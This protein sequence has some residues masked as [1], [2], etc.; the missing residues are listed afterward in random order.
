MGDFNAL[1]FTSHLL[2][3][4]GRMAMVIEHP[5]YFVLG[6]AGASSLESLKLYELRLRLSLKKYRLLARSAPFWLVVVGM[7]AASGFVAWA[8]HVDTEGA[9]V[10]HVVMTGMAA[11]SIVREIGAAR[12]ATRPATLGPADEERVVLADV[13]R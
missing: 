5:E 9:T 8:M 4:S 2:A 3:F 13:F 6:A 1:D 12:A 7:L 11:R 10:W